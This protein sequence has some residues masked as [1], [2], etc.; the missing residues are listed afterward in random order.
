MRV[1]FD[2]PWSDRSSPLKPV[3]VELNSNQLNFYEFAAE[4]QTISLLQSLFKFQNYDDG[5]SL[6]DEVADKSEPYFFDGDAYGDDTGGDNGQAL[7]SR[8]RNRLEKLKQDKLLAT[9]Y[10]KDFYG[11]GLLLEPTSDR[12]TY[13]VFASKYRGSVIQSFTLQNLS[14]GEAPSVIL[15]NYKEDKQKHSNNFALV[16]YRNALRL[17]V[18]YSQLLLHFWSFHGMAFWF[19][20]LSVGKDLSTCIDSR[21]VSVLKSI[22]RNFTTANNA[23]LEASAREALTF[24]PET[25]KLE[26]RGSITLDMTSDGLSIWDGC[27]YSTQTSDDTSIGSSVGGCKRSSVDVFGLRITCY[28]N[29]FT[30]IEKQYISNCIPVLNSFD[31][32]IGSKMTLSNYEN[33]MPCNDKKNVNKEGKIFISQCTFN[34]MVRKYLKNSKAGHSGLC[35]DFYVDAAGLVA[36]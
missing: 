4:K 24:N 8:L 28:E 13:E 22:P 35:K 32:W 36:I 20:N 6:H 19:R 17:R 23:L 25:R 2:T 33:F 1:E 27:S 16:N 7:F 3:V 12:K 26:H 9:L 34:N 30:P 14:V 10:P 15:C 21:K 18:E 5:T 11:N 29:Y 31:K